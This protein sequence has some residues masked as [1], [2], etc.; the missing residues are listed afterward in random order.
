MIFKLYYFKLFKH[1]P[2]KNVYFPKVWLKVNKTK[3]KKE[4]YRNK[5]SNKTIIVFDVKIN[6]RFLKYH[7]ITEFYF[8]VTQRNF[9]NIYY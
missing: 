7:S 2:F 1:E 3:Y 4:E 5:E 6:V 9:F 8:S